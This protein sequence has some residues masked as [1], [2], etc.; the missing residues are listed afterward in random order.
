MTMFNSIHAS[1]YCGQQKLE[2]LIRIMRVIV[3]SIP[4]LR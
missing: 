3:D 4:Q 2:E 1:S